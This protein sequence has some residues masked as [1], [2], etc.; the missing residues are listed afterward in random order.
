VIE[1]G[2]L[3]GL[4]VVGP[5]SLARLRWVKLGRTVGESIEILSGLTVGERLLVDAST[6]IEGA[7]IED[8]TR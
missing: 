2:E 4:Y 5:D 7:R 6:G 8:A 3:T 1:R